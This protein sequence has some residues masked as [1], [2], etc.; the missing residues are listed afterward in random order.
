[1]KG[2]ASP[3]HEAT[4]LKIRAAVIAARFFLPREAC[5][6]RGLTEE[7][8]RAVLALVRR[9]VPEF[10][11]WAER[12]GKDNPENDERDIW[13][14]PLHFAAQLATY[15]RARGQQA[16]AIAQLS[17]LVELARSTHRQWRAISASGLRRGVIGSLGPFP[18]PWPEWSPERRCSLSAADGFEWATALDRVLCNDFPL[19]A[20]RLETII[21][22]LKACKTR[23]SPFLHASLWEM[24]VWWQ[25]ATERNPTY[26]DNR[27]AGE[28]APATDFQQL[29]AILLPQEP[30][31]LKIIKDVVDAFQA[32]LQNSEFEELAP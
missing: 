16:S 7:Q 13:A 32:D 29:V 30:V 5:E 25:Q 4:R 3:R 20:D 9:R 17:R 28:T 1:M 23:A 10:F 31:S 18:S 8:K 19:L 24:A 15:S 27:E 21:G 11:D 22:G 26:T 6:V 2:S 14:L 12:A